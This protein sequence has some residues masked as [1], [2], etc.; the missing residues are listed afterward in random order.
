MWINLEQI[1]DLKA[2]SQE[3]SVSAASEKLG[4]AK[5]AIHYSIKKLEDQLG[6]LVLN[7]SSYRGKLTPK[8]NQFL[9][10]AEKLLYE[11]EQLKNMAHQIASGAEIRLKMSTTALYSIKKLNQNIIQ[12]QKEFPDTEF[13]L[14]REILS[15]ELMLRKEIVDIAIVEDIKDTKSFESKKIGKIRLPLVVAASHPFLSL[16]KSERTH[17]SLKTFPQVIQKSTI[18]T[19]AAEGVFKTTKHW[20]VT[21]LDSKKQIILDGLGWGRLPEHEI[22]DE[23][24]A[25]ELV[26]LR[27]IEKPIE[28][29]LFLARRRGPVYGSVS[30]KIWEMDWK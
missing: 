25:G 6:F 26:V 4:R 28:L 12:I 9:M 1:A 5:S 20:T 2:V 30:Q 29:E 14:T 11:V 10:Q 27:Q 16:K 17:E 18:E 13:V 15:G 7:T 19:D 3:G 22:D 8:G 21:D 24:Q 23:I